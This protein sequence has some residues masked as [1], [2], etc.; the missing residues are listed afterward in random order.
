MV[1]SASAQEELELDLDTYDALEF[2]VRGDGR[3][4]IATLRT[5]SWSVVPVRAPRPPR[6]R[7]PLTVNCL[8]GGAHDLWQSFLFAPPGE[9]AVVRLPLS[10]FLK[11]WK[12]KIVDGEG[13]MNARRVLSLGVSLAGGGALDAPGAYSLELEEVRAVRGGGRSRQ[14]SA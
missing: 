6:I 1:D 13:E 9:W 11:T 4:Y 12:G 10:R 14:G 7:Y 5:D 8:Q 2:R 3:K